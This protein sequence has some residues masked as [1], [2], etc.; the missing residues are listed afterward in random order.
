MTFKLYLDLFLA[1]LK[2]GVTTFGGGPSAIPLIEEEVVH[3]Y[4]WLTVEEFTDALAFG[5]S[6]PGPIATKLAA[7]VGYKVSGWIGSI[8][9]IF[10]I[11]A[12]TAIA[13]VLFLNIYLKYKNTSWLKGMMKAVRPVV[14]VLLVQVAIN[15]AQKSFP[16]FITIAIAGVAGGLIFLTEIHPAL[17]ILSSIIF[18][19]VFFK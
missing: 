18:G 7:L 9:S 4:G 16:D 1:F 6:L 2:P 12:P 10:A 19:G 17:I 11:V 13:I 3:N 15:M 14:V 5:N 8:I